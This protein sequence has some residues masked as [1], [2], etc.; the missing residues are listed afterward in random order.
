MHQLQHD[1]DR[2]VLLTAG[3]ISEQDDDVEW[4]GAGPA[5][6]RIADRHP[7][8]D[9]WLRGKHALHRE[10]GRSSPHPS[11]S[12]QPL[13]RRRGYYRVSS[14]R[15]HRGDQLGA[16]RDDCRVCPR[17]RLALIVLWLVCSR[18]PERSTGPSRDTGKPKVGRVRTG[19][20]AIFWC[21]AWF[22][23]PD[24]DG[25]AARYRRSA[26]LRDCRPAPGS[27][28]RN[29]FRGRQIWASVSGRATWNGPL[30]SA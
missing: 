17:P 16:A 25:D 30:H 8:Y 21:S 9:F 3:S 29:R 24:G 7:R 12:S 2:A 26:T 13:L 22:R 27:F 15:Q 11:G 14:L 6:R 5:G 10:R 1:D 20:H 28:V 23:P 18:L 19:R 4:L